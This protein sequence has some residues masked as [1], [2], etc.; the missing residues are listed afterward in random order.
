VERVMST[1][2]SNAKVRLL[3]IPNSLPRLLV[4]HTTVDAIAAIL[5]EA[6]EEAAAELCGFISRRIMVCMDPSSLLQSAANQAASTILEAGVDRR[7]R[8]TYVR[9]PSSIL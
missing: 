7:K 8:P 6:V 2:I 9:S 3:A 5:S 1:Y 4:G